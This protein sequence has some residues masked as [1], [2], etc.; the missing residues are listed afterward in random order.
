[1]NTNSRPDAFPDTEP[2]A[3][4]PQA[5][6]PKRDPFADLGGLSLAPAEVTL[7]EAMA[8]LHKDNRV[9]P[10]P[11]RWLEFYRVLQDA[12]AGKKLPSPPFSGSA[13]ASTPVA[14]KRACFREQMEWA[15]A[16]AC[17][18]PAYEFIKALPDSDWFCA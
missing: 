15:E 12:A 11:T 3:L 9:C 8:E 13:W 1:M 17:L 16:N 10:L 7:Y 18:Q 6:A 14:A 4:E 2:M 5:P